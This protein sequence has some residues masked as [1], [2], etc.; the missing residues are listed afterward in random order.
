M[1]VCV[2]RLCYRSVV[3]SLRRRGKL[4]S[5]C[6]IAGCNDEA[7]LLHVRAGKPASGFHPVGFVSGSRDGSCAVGSLPELGSYDRL[8][9]VVADNDIECVLI[10]SSDFAHKDVTNMVQSLRG[11]PVDMH[12]S[13]GL[14]EILTSRVLVR[15]IGGVPMVTVRRVSMTPG[16]RFL[17]RAIDVSVALA[18]IA[19]MMPLWLLI[20]LA[21]KVSSR[22]PIFY[23]QQRV[24][25][26]RQ[27]FHML[28]F[29]SMVADADQ[30]VA[31]LS[32]QRGT[33]DILFKI[34][35]DPRATRVGRWIRKHSLDEFPQLIN[36]VRGHM[37]LVGPRPAL[38]SEVE[39]YEGW[40]MRRLEVL[41]GMTGLWQVSGRSDLPFDEAVRLDIF[42]IENWS[43]WLDLSTLART[44]PVVFSS[45]GAY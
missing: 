11:V 3:K 26:N 45:N 16:K 31:E 1:C 10:A 43:P 13:S 38:V 7:R 4:R 8:P 18:G 23:R 6:L 39:R 41:P 42:Y 27:T 40:H 15:E 20:A 28:K 9:D 2:G 19:L 22:G 33:Q 17:K 5:R 35:R 37:S 14:F 25:R 24:G 21:V 29:R 36:V 32:R 30:Q 34:R 44:V 12:V